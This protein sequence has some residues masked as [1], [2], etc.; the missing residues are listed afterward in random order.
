MHERWVSAYE[1]YAH[2]GK[3]EGGMLPGEAGENF[4]IQPSALHPCISSMVLLSFSLA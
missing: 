2:F 3:T 4:F 1:V